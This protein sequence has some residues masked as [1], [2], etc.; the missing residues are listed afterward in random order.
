VIASLGRSGTDIK[1]PLALI[2][3]PTREL[4]SQIAYLM[5]QLVGGA[6]MTLQQATKYNGP[7][8]VRIGCVLDD[9]DATFGL[10]LQTDIAVTTPQYLT[11]LLSDGDIVPSKLRVI[12]YDEADLALEQTSAY[13]LNQLFDDDSS[14]REFTRLSFLVGASVTEALGKLAISSRI[15]PEGQSYIA[16]ATTYAPLLSSTTNVMNTELTNE[17]D[18]R[19]NGSR[20]MSEQIV[21]TRPKSASLQDLDVCMYPGLTHERVIVQDGNLRL[22]ILTRLIRQELQK[23]EA[24]YAIDN[25]IQRPRVVVFFPDEV[26]AKDAIVPLRDALWGEHKLCVLLPKTGFSPMTIMEQFKRNETSVMLAT[27]NSVRG[28]DF[29]AL[30]HCYTLYLPIDDPREYIHLA[31]RVGRVGHQSKGRVISILSEKDAYQMDDLA[32]QLNFTFTDVKAPTAESLL[33]RTDDGTIDETAIDYEK[34]RRAFEDTISFVDPVD[35]PIIDVMS[36]PTSTGNNM[37]DDDEDEDDD[38]EIEEETEFQ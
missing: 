10:K 24:A 19:N 17:I 33:P 6:S 4:G 25:T 8:G 3:V 30:T 16:T 12:V 26:Q 18:I 5:Y 11:K 14:N 35:E 7:K 32:R 20:I 23:Y 2:V 15:L 1:S 28:L 31:G 34:L 21:G 9:D 22:L 37:D 13:D 27:P 29:P 38:T 36:I